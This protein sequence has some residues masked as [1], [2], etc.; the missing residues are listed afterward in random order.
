V[1]WDRHGTPHNLGSLGGDEWN[2]P[3][4]VTNRGVVVGF[5]NATGGA[6]FQPV[7]FVWTARTGMRALDAL[8]GDQVS[9][10]LGA[11]DAGQIVGESCGAGFA[12]CHAVL[13]QGDRPVDLNS[14]VD[15]PRVLAN[16]DDINNRGRITGTLTD[17]DASRAFVAVPVDQAP[18]R[19][20][21]VSTRTD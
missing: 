15:T 13:W 16:A 5:A 10:A 1:L 4:A 3:L 19:S 17:G 9:E 18:G 21:G 14:V 2:T 6:A 20:A 11:N 7:A 12:D 8:P